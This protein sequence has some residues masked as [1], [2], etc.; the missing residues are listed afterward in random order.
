MRRER[1]LTIVECL[2]AMTILSVIVLVTCHTL[3][4]GQQ[5]VR[6]GDR[7]TGA[8]RLGRDLLEEIGARDYRDA[9]T[10]TNF[11]RETGETARAHFDDV[12]DYN[13]Y[14]ESAGTIKDFDGNFYPA[15]DQTYSRSVAVTA[16]TR[17]VTNLARDFPGLNVVV[18]VR[19]NTG[20]QWKFTRFIPEP[21]L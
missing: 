9:T 12:D 19:S 1:G 13:A 17:T 18:T 16:T 4:A 5:H 3:A 11:G 20:E 2:I 10:P 15:D 6:N 8:A 14:T 21:G 7:L